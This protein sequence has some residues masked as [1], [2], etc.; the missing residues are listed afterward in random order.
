[1]FIFKNI[2]SAQRFIGLNLNIILINNFFNFSYYNFIT[3][4]H[5]FK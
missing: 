5:N 1:M 3:I 2:N 4:D